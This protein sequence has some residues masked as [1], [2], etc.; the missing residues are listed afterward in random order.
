MKI[1]CP[2]CG[3]MFN[4]TLEK[5][6]SCGAPNTGVQ[7][8]YKGQPQTIEQLAQWYKDRGLPPYEKTRFFIGEDYR[9]PR[10][11]GIYKDPNTG[12]FVVYKNKDSGER[13]IR[14]EGTDEAYA[15]NELF[16]RLKQEII[17]QKA[18]NVKGGSSSPSRGSG[19][20][21]VKNSKSYKTEKK[22][23]W[24]WYYNLGCF[25][26][27]LAFIVTLFIIIVGI[28][29]S[30][31]GVSKLIDHPEAGYYKIDDQYRYCTDWGDSIPGAGWIIYNPDDES[32]DGVIDLKDDKAELRKNKTAQKYFISSE[33]NENIGCPDFLKSKDYTRISGN[34]YVS[35]GYYDYDGTTYYHQG[36]SQDVGWYEY[37]TDDG[38]QRADMDALP[39]ELQQTHWAE[40]FYY[41]PEWNS[42]TQITD[43]TQSEYY[44]APSSSSD[45]DD[46]DW[47]DNYN[48][49]S[50]YD[51]DS[52]SSW[53]SGSTDWD[54]DW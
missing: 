22:T 54:S 8:T 32:W 33:W 28:G 16:Q 27:C 34:T 24:D 50:D 1:Q 37:D 35:Q 20:S 48:D 30:I 29:F 21:Q 36:T 49:D 53:D 6:P 47:W 42:D 46:D 41:T 31:A 5:C 19:R 26:S 17:Q 23:F 18:H 12:N 9:K 38:W 52:G 13:A 15:V 43:F 10:A 51:W 11:F 40:D 14:Y 4:D 7:R 39:E 25:N 44:I 3:N 2:Y 45:D